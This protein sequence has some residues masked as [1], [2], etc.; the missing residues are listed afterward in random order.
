MG[1]LTRKVVQCASAQHWR[2]VNLA[3]FEKI[4]TVIIRVRDLARA[5]QWYQEALGLSAVF[6]DDRERVVTFGFDGGS[7]AG[8]HPVVRAL[9]SRWEPVRGVPVLIARPGGVK[10]PGRV[11]Q[12]HTPACRYR[13]DGMFIQVSASRMPSLGKFW[14][15]V[16]IARISEL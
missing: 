3:V 2:G 8:R 10:P 14:T 5:R 13:T 7:R 15:R 11:G 6:S 1:R 16:L 12:H 9:G 4:A